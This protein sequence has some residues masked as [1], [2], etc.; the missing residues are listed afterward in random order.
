MRTV[1]YNCGGGIEQKA[2]LSPELTCKTTPP[3]DK[4]EGRNHH[5]ERAI[6]LRATRAGGGRLRIKGPVNRQLFD[7][8]QWTLDIGCKGTSY[9]NVSVMWAHF[10]SPKW[11]LMQ[12]LSRKGNLYDILEFFNHKKVKAVNK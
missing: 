1:V 9:N 2:V 3:E 12:Q 11:V 7:S 4:K 10:A 5:V 8:L 6:R